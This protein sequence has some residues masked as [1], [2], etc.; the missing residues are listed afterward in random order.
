M[1]EEMVWNKSQWI[2]EFAILYVNLV[3]DTYQAGL[4]LGDICYEN[5]MADDWPMTPQEVLYN[6]VSNWDYC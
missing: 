1:I 2:A 6:E 3:K 5:M 4:E